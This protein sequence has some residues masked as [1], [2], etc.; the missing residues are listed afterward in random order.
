MKALLKPF[1]QIISIISI[2][3]FFFFAEL[4]VTNDQ[5]LHETKGFIIWVLSIL[6]G[7]SVALIMKKYNISNLLSKI[8]L[9]VSVL[10]I[11][12][13]ILTGLIYSIV[14]SMS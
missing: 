6:I 14:S 5:L 11:F 9:I 4:W 7:G 8:T 1:A 2:C 10:S 12:L 3:I 13:L